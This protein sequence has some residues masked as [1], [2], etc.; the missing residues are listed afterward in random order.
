[1]FVIINRNSDKMFFNGIMSNVWHGSARSHEAQTF[2][3]ESKCLETLNRLCKMQ[4][5]NDLI[6]IEV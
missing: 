2:N 6:F 4:P 5:Q 1:M 3:D